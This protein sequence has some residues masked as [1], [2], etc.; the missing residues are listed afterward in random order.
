MDSVVACNN[1]FLS[2]NF[3][4]NP[5]IPSLSPK[6]TINASVK[7]IVP[8]DR[9]S[10]DISTHKSAIPGTLVTPRVD[11]IVPSTSTTFSNSNSLSRVTEISLTPAISCNLVTIC[12]DNSIS[13]LAKHVF[14]CKSVICNA[15]TNGC[16]A[17]CNCCHVSAHKK[18]YS[19]KH[20]VAKSKTCLNCLPKMVSL[21]AGFFMLFTYLC[22]IIFL[23]FVLTIISVAINL[24]ILLKFAQLIITIFYV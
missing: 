12:S 5:T 6:P 24:K 21:K 1:N 18:R 9:K 16:D 19:A 14:I 3:P 20:F 17:F 22:E 7:S 11:S 4:I 8:L 23:L 2:N 10:D 13:F 15:P